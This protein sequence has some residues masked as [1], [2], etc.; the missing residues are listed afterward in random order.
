[1]IKERFEDLVD[2]VERNRDNNMD[3]VKRLISEFREEIDGVIKSVMD[4]SNTGE[5]RLLRKQLKQIV[6]VVVRMSFMRRQE[7]KQELDG[8]MDVIRSSRDDIKQDVML[9]RRDQR[10]ETARTVFAL[11]KHLRKI[12][13]MGVERDEKAR[14]RFYRTLSFIANDMTTLKKAHKNQLLMLARLLVE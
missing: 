9:V 8:V 5:L 10:R 4:S 12:I 1:M 11:A 3:N 7:L 14:V 6:A 13:S 2:L